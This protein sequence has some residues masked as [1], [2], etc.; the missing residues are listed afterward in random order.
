M[1]KSMTGFG[2]SSKEMG[3]SVVTV[4]MKA[5]NHRYSEI[6]IRLPR[7]LL[8]LEDR[9]KKLISQFVSRGKVDVFINLHGSA[10][11]ERQVV[12]DWAIFDQYLGVYQQMIERSDSSGEFPVK[13][14]LVH[15]DVVT[16]QEREAV[17]DELT[18]TVEVAVTEAVEQLHLMRREEGRAL[19]DDLK[20][21]LETLDSFLNQLR[22][23]APVAAK[24][25]EL[26]LKKR[27]QELVDQFGSFEEQRVLTEVAI[28]AEKSDYAEELTRMDSHL[29]QFKTMTDESIPV[30]RKLDFLMQEMNREVN[31]IGSKA[32]HLDVN[33]LVVS[34]KSELEKIREQIQNIE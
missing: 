15:E 22:D 24:E 31:T 1:M 19:H 8:F 6:N 11:T 34:V 12:V 25:Y 28:F 2:R 17:A 18:G 30:G 7:Q 21:R 29:D 5:V 32:N 10:G 33:H 26:R 4:E 13:E 16:V 27:M 14:L 20:T 3:N 9:L 23:L